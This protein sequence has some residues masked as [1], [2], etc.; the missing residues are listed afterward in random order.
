MKIEPGYYKTRDGRKARVLHVEDGARLRSKHIGFFLH[1]IDCVSC[2]WAED[3]KAT[4][5]GADS[6]ADLIS[7]WIDEPK[8]VPHWPAVISFDGGES[9]FVCDDVFPSLEAAKKAQESPQADRR[10]IKL[11]DE[12]PGIMLPEKGPHP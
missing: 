3:G 10:V 1:G 5:Y 12:W 9:Y 8:L 2:T 6:D 11:A 4:S 7:P